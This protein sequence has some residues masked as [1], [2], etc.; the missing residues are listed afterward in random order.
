MR[1]VQRLPL[2]KK[3]SF[4]ERF[5]SLLPAMIEAVELEWRVQ[6]PYMDAQLQA[7]FSPTHHG[8]AGLLELKGYD[9]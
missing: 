7:L 1:S 6:R 3:G 2:R 8:L 9:Q 5:E 4:S